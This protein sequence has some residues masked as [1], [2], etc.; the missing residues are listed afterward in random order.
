MLYKII[1]IIYHVKMDL[2]DKPIAGLHMLPPEYTPGP[3]DILLGYE[4][5]Y[6]SN[7]ILV[8]PKPSEMNGL[9][10]LS[11]IIL[12]VFF[13]PAACIPCCL[14]TSYNK[15]QRPVYG[16]AADFLSFEYVKE[17]DIPDNSKINRDV[18]LEHN[19][20]TSQIDLN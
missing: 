3:T 14:S 19:F 17:R 18:I 8:K 20:L 9:G 6:D 5:V 13:L 16:P 10:W 11:V 2:H 15:A 4:I 7:Q 12:S 1:I